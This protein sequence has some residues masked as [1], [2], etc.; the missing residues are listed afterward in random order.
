LQGEGKSSANLLRALDTLFEHPIQTAAGL[1]DKLK[2]S[3]P[4]AN[5]LISRLQE[6]G[7][8]HEQTGYKRNRRFSYDPYL[9][10]FDGAVT[11]LPTSA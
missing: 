6:L 2:L 5:G 1:A 11:E 3:Y 4:T 9:R 10:L 7:V 8:L